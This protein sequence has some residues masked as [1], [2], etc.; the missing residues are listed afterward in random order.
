M[1]EMIRAMPPAR[2]SAVI[3]SG[4]PWIAGYVV[5]AQDER[6]G[7]HASPRGLWWTEVAR[8]E[9]ERLW[10]TRTL[11]TWRDHEF[12]VVGIEGEGDARSVHLVDVGHDAFAAESLDL[13]KTDAGVYEAVVPAGELAHMREA[14]TEV[15]S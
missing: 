13:T 2:V 14:Q 4:L 3:G 9:L 7:W 8:S 12:Q 15:P 5:R 11:A 1:A 10:V 6:D